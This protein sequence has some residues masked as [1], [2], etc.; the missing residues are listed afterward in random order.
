MKRFL[1]GI[2]LALLVFAT[3]AR[4]DVTSAG[5]GSGGVTKGTFVKLSAAKTIVTATGVGDSVVGVCEQTAAADALSKY[6]L[7]GTRTVVIAPGGE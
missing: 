5:A 4:A 2:M 6:S 7:P 1:I 3:A